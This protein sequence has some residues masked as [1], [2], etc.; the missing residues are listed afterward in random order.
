MY[1][2]EEEIVR[3]LIDNNFCDCASKV[4]SLSKV[5]S[6]SELNFVNY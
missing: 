4:Y 1:I 3:I 2:V 6:W 5:Y